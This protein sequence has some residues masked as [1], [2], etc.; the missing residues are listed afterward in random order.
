MD[1]IS[2]QTQTPPFPINKGNLLNFD[3]LVTTRA[4]TDWSQFDHIITEDDT[5]VDN[6]N[7]Y[8]QQQLLVDSLRHSYAPSRPFLPLAN[9]GLFSNPNEPP[10]VPD[11]LLSL[12]VQTAEDWRNKK[13]RSYFTWVFGKVPE[14]VIEIVSNK[15]GGEDSSKIHD[16]AQIGIPHYIILDPLQL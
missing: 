12:D 8:Q 4:P 9:V 1:A 14:V 7:S 5:P 3:D 13:N 16:Y 11:V 15:I 10:I 6:I 2:T